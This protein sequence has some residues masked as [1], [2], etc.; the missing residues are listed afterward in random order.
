MCTVEFTQG[1]RLRL[2]SLYTVF[3]LVNLHSVSHRVCVCVCLCIP[4][5]VCVYCCFW[6]WFCYYDARF[7]STEMTP[8]LNCWQRNTTTNCTS[9]KSTA[10]TTTA[11]TKEQQQKEASSNKARQDTKPSINVGH[12]IETNCRQTWQQQ[13]Q[14]RSLYIKFVVKR[15]KKDSK[16]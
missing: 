10:T 11:T 13:K 2:H 3:N 16:G 9:N 14:Q 12:Q 1:F 5:P 7:P 6:A 15:M 8:W 4:M